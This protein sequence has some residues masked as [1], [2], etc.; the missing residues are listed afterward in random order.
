MGTV[1]QRMRFRRRVL[2][3][4]SELDRDAFT[5]GPADAPVACLLIHGFS[6]SPL[7]MRWLGTYLAERGIRVEGVRLAGHGTEPEALTH[8]TWHDWLQS[9]SEG[10]ERLLIGR[11]Q[12]VVVGFSMGGLLAL[13]L[14]AAYPNKISKVVTISSPIYFRDQRIHLIP[15]VRHVVR[16]HHIRRPGTSTDPEA[17]TRYH[18]YRRYPLIA[19]DHLLDLM[20]V[21]RKLVPAIQTPALV[22]HG[23]LDH[24]VH[25]K[26]ASYLFRTLGSGRKELVWWQNSGHGVPFDAE[27][28]EVWR[29]VLLFVTAQV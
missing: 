11:E 23:L 9:A 18:A 19:V 8:L 16:W 25:P 20:R 6:G 21:T 7:E 14:C 13:Q 1:F 5:F 12:V 27:R 17:H 22:M 26:S 29:K 3:P 4:Q 2:P 24:V 28:E 10:L 15:V